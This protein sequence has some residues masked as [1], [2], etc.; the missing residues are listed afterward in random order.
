MALWVCGVQQ[1]PTRIRLSEE[2]TRSLENWINNQAFGI[3]SEVRPLIQFN[4]VPLWLTVIHC[5]IP[6]I[7]TLVERQVRKRMRHSLSEK[8][9]IPFEGDLSLSLS[10][11]LSIQT[12]MTENDMSMGWAGDFPYF[13]SSLPVKKPKKKHKR[14]KREKRL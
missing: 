4:N 9:Y 13:T 14:R 11:T 12:M 10:R 2:W 6:L 7:G 8:T 1:H 3:A 5:H